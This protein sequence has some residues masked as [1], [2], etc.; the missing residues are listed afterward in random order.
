MSEAMTQVAQLLTRMRE[1]RG[2]SPEELA[3]KA[4]APVDTILA[5]EADPS[6]LSP[7]AALS[8]FE[9]MPPIE[10]DNL[11]WSSEPPPPEVL[12]RM[13]AKMRELEAAMR[14]DQR[15]FRD[16]LELLDRGLGLFPSR[17]RRGRLL[18]SKAAVLGELSREE[19]ALL[20]LREAESC[21]SRIDEPALWL[22]L[23]LEQM[24]FLCQTERY[25]EA[26]ALLEEVSRLADR[27]GRDRE[28]LQARW[29]SGWIAA[30]RGRTEDAVRTLRPVR[31]ELLAAGR[32]VEAAGVALDLAALQSGTEEVAE[33]RRELEPL[34]EEKS[35]TKDARMAVKVFCWAVDRGR[36]DAPMG[37][38]LA[39]ELRRGGGRLMRPYEIPV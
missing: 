17:D 28:R 20:A 9:A 14:I 5:Y 19:K 31:Q 2:W 10:K 7:E 33:L 4:G 6:S 30:G 34:I 21:L 36:L 27:V 1:L 35:L 16:A 37:R 39:A 22:R 23:R 15:R 11:L 3:R 29:M 38:R 26:E 8:I 32:L 13:E 12:L 24:Y 25:P 18:L